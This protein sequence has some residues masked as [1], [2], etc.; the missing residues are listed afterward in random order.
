MSGHPS[1]KYASTTRTSGMNG[2]LPNTFLDKPVP[3]SLITGQHKV[4]D[5]SCNVCATLLGWKY[6]EADEESQK[7]KVGKFI[8]ESRRTRIASRW[9]NPE[10]TGFAT[11]PLDGSGAA[12]ESGPAD[13]ELDL[14]SQDEDEC[15]DLFA[16]IWSPGLARRRR[17]RK[18]ER[19][20]RKATKIYLPRGS[21]ESL[22]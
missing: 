8:L 16:G 2:A 18:S 13:E 10:G 20:K 3:R 22:S 5:L 4:A 1:S 17:Q 6:V 7:Y 12:E 9:D 19:F 21:Q 11:S 14:D 15:E